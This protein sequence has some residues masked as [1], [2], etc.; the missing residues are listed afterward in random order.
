M[1][2][3]WPR[4]VGDLEVC[5]IQPPARENRIREPHYGT[6]Q[7]LAASLVEFLPPYL[8]RPFAFFGH[9]GGVLPG[10]E[11]TL[12]LAAAGL[13]LPHRLFASSQVAPHDGPYGRFLDLDAEGL[14][15]ELRTLIASQGGTPSPALVTMGLGLLERDIDANRRYVVPEPQPLPCGVTAIGWSEDREIPFGLMGGWRQLADDVRMVRLDGGHHDFLSAPPAL[16]A[17][18]E[19]DMSAAVPP[20]VH[21]AAPSGEGA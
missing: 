11:L 13:P 17:E 10:V 12:Q 9:C 14:A 18:L 4:S 16:L 5:L 19:R 15:E 1:Y 7:E 21:G 8:D 6:Y 2:H 20:N 3:R